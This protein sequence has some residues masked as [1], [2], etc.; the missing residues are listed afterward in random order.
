[1]KCDY[2][3]ANVTIDDRECPYCH[4][5]NTH[6]VKHREAM[7]HYENAYSKTRQEVYEKAGRVSQNAV[8][9]T[10]LTVMIVLILVLVLANAGSWRIARMIR[11][12]QVNRRFNTHVAALE[13][14][15]D[16]GDFDGF[17][18]YY[19]VQDLSVSEAMRD[20]Y[21]HAYMA[22][23]NAQ[24]ILIGCEQLVDFQDS[25]VAYRAPDQCVKDIA[26]NLFGEY[27]ARFKE[28]LDARLAIKHKDFEKAKTMLGGA[29]A[30]YLDNPDDAKA[31]SQA[32]KIAINSV[33]GLTSASFENPFRDPRNIDNIVAKRGALFMINLKH[34]VQKRGFTVVH[35]KT[36]SIKVAD[37]TP[38]IMDFILEYGRQ[39]GYN[40]EIEHIFER[41]CLVNDAVY[42]A[43]LAEDD[44]DA[45]GEWTA[46]GKQFAVPYVFKT[47]F[48]HEEIKFEDM[49]E[50]K[51][52]GT[53]LYLDM[54]EGFKDVSY[55][56][57][58][59]EKLKKEFDK[60]KIT[61]MQY[62]EGQDVLNEAI[63]QGHNYIFVGKVGAFT[64]VIAGAGGGE[65]MRIEKDG[66]YSA[67]TGTK[68]YRWMESEMVKSLGYEDKID[69]SYYI[70]LVNNAVASL[71]EFG[72]VEK[73][74]SDDF[75]EEEFTAMNKPIE[76]YVA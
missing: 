23:M 6:Y 55:E 1:M 41:I 64:P 31:L 32:L 48:S 52:A 75:Y 19:L 63:V 25:E 62:Q 35:I 34:E 21:S 30:K 22:A 59:L 36:D 45:P 40:F 43:K 74:L 28:L 17:T 67:A 20:E 76:T 13:A 68:G 53:A 49:C 65:L 58:E 16:E 57:Q 61:K 5:L 42:I 70:N 14:Y 29:L 7:Q 44:P 24:Q 10:I 38:E 72:D 9:V 18:N 69:K 2:C 54:N 26:E 11:S 56:E 12:Y 37:P 51:S 39:Y 33:Y 73:F 60:G 71:N 15:M 50:T 8:R 66:R 3:G 47:L 27:T 46:T 4:S